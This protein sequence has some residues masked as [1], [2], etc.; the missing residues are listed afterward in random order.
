[1]P[2]YAG[3]SLLTAL[4]TFAFIGFS[5]IGFF[6]LIR[7][8]LSWFCRCK[9]THMLTSGRIPADVATMLW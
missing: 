4:S 8:T 6:L 2:V 9:P 5:S 7:C 1:M 3:T